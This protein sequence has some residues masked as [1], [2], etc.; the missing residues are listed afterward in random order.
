MPIC[1]TSCGSNQSSWLGR[2]DEKLPAH[3]CVVNHLRLVGK[4]SVKLDSQQLNDMLESVFAVGSAY[5]PQR[6]GEM[7][8]MKCLSRALSLR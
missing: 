2:I 1:L 7:Q 8:N 5:W 6:Y 4:I 3:H